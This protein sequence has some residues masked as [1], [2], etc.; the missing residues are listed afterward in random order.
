VLLKD[1]VIP[2]LPSPYY[3]FK[4]DASGR[5]DSVSF[6]SEL[7]RYAVQYTGGKI[8]GLTNN[9]LVNHDRLAY[10]YDG[11]GHV[12]EV[13]YIDGSGIVFTRVQLGYTGNQLTSLDR[14]LLLGGVFVHDK[15]MTFAYGADGNLSDL[16]THRLPVQGFQTD[17]TYTDHFD[18]YD[19]GVN[20][21]G[22]SLIHDDFFD[23]LVLL[24]DVQLQK[25]NA[26]R[27]TR[28]G[29]VDNYRVEFTYTYDAKNRP[30]SQ[31]GDLLYLTGNL[32]GQHFTVGATYSYY[33]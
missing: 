19:S 1:I 18:R 12:R 21:D 22:F 27:V 24:P 33:D 17:V 7:T 9:I 5:I 30:T 26:H 11:A 23:H 4:Y 3:H 28:S 16:T 31:T 29:Q 13:T 15:T 25:N 8:S 6:A 14:Q 32:T 2:N 20:V 10:A